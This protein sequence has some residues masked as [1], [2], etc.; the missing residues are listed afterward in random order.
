[1]MREPCPDSFGPPYFT[2]T[3]RKR[4]FSSEA[5]A[6]QPMDPRHGPSVIDI[7]RILFLLMLGT[8]SSQPAR[9][10]YTSNALRETSTKYTVQSCHSI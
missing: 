9:L 1:M 3:A 5:P 2:V 4:E 8:P 10:L 7:P 6:D